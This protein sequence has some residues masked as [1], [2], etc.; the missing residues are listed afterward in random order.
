MP[1]ITLWFLQ[2]SRCI[3]I[4]WLLEELHLDYDVKFFDRENG[5]APQALK[6]GSGNPLGKAPT[7]QDG[8]LTIY[9][10]G[11]ITRYLCEKYDKQARLIPH[12][13]YEVDRIKVQQ[14]IHASEATF[15]LHALAISSARS[16]IPEPGKSN[17]A[18]KEMEKKMSGNV[19][20]DVDWLEAELGQSNGKFLLGK[21]VT[22]ADIMMHISIVFILKR[23]LGTQGRTWPKVEQWLKDCEATDSYKR[24][25]QKT[26]HKV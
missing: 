24:A 15:I 6:S 3:R 5:I 1:P 2:A 10:S 12:P 22:A 14:W 8:P 26:G 18:L 17:G 11:A 16:T 13:A 19:Q 21:E 7:L 4:A 23:E 9:E 20:N 25:V